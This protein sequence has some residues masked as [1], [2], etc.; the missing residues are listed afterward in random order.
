MKP[1]ASHTL[2]WLIFSY[3]NVVTVARHSK[4]KDIPVTIQISTRDKAGFKFL[5]RGA[6]ASKRVCISRHST[7]PD[8]PGYRAHRYAGE[9]FYCYI[10]IMYMNLLTC[11]RKY[12]DWDC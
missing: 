7:F 1:R 11:H 10:G 4:Y 2:G 8:I 5:P 3:S 9:S 12:E 6:C